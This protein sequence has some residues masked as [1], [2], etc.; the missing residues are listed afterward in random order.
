MCVAFT[1][2]C[3]KP[4]MLPLYCPK[5]GTREKPASDRRLRRLRSMIISPGRQNASSI[6][7]ITAENKGVKEGGG[8]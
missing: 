8:G 2:M 4:R 1:F 7:T 6:G 5:T 3:M